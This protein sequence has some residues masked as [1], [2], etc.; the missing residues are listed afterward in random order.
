MSVY[1][2]GDLKIPEANF[3]LVQ[4]WNDGTACWKQDGKFMR[5]QWQYVSDHG[6]LVDVDALKAECKEP[7]VWWETETQ[8][9]EILKDAPVVIPAERSENENGI[10]DHSN[11]RSNQG[12]AEPVA[13]VDAEERHG[14]K[15]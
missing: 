7:Y 15:G 13:V 2:T 8:M 1:I 11:M 12:G 5:G 4:L 3:R 6:D 10:M 9:A 14:R